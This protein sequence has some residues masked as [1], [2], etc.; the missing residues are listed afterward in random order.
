MARLPLVLALVIGAAA[1]AS[2]GLECEDAAAIK[3]LEAF[4]KD[5]AKGEEVGRNYSWL[6]VE[7]GAQRLKPRIEKAC[8]KIL[9]RDGENSECVVAAAAAGFAKLGDHDIFALVGKLPDDPID[10]AGGIGFTKADLFERIGDPR[11]AQLLV[12]AWKTA[13]PRADAREKRHRSMVDWSSWRQNTAHVLG[14]LGDAD[15]KT[16]L[17]DQAKATKDTHVRDAC[18][19]AASAIGKRV[20]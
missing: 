20:K 17:E 19:T 6:C 12:D 8:K 5:K 9:D 13:I 1:P 16:F 7:F 18:T 11:G 14:T 2:A 10:Y 4:A 3:D 15:T